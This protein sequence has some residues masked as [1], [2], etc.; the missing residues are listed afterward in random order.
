MSNIQK[1]LNLNPYQLNKKE[2]NK[3]FFNFQKNLSLFHKK[4]CTEYK[5]ISTL[6]FKKLNKI[7]KLSDLPYVHSNIFKNYHLK[8]TNRNSFTM[9]SSGTSKQVRSKVNIDFQTS[10]LQAE[11]LKKIIFDFIP[12]DIDTIIIIENEKNINK[13]KF[14]DAK[15]VAIKGISRNFKKKIFILKQNNSID[16]NKIIKL[17]KNH[18]LN[19]L[20][21][22]GMTDN[23]WD[24]L[25][26]ELKENK[27][28]FPKNN[29]YLIHGGGWKK[30]QNR[31]ISKTKF[32]NE[33]KKI[34]N[35]KKIFNYYGMI[36][37]A[38]SIY[39]E[40]EKGYFHSSIFSDILI[41]DKN[42]EIEKNERFGLIQTMSVL[43]I[44]YPGHNI[45]T[46]DLGAIIGEDDCKCGR[47]GKYFSYLNR[48]KD[49]EA[50]G[51]SNV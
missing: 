50:R 39:M 24:N 41:R 22:F 36:E 18:K 23:V 42:L 46:E 48:V 2:K 30:L 29:W 47:K 5:K 15:T 10:I 33:V 26:E 19:K 34:T 49:A 31:S 14:I 6:F 8:S 17:I 3:L 38:G 37:Q 12:K 43:P 9:N 44:S 11:V 27:I 35:V 1:F 7:N 25:L 45:L 40:C 21:F 51:C 4:N 16:K 13:Q 32:I 28:R 20:L